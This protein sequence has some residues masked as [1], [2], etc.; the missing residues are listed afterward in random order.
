MDHS[1]TRRD[2]LRLAGATSLGLGLAGCAPAHSGSGAGQGKREFTDAEIPLITWALTSPPRSLDPAH[3][4]DGSSEFTYMEM[5]E[6]LVRFDKNGAPQNLLA[7]SWARPDPLTYVIQLRP[8]VFFWDGKP[9][10]AE[11]AA[12][13]IQRNV[14]PAVASEVAG[15]YAGLESATATGPLELTVK[16]KS[17]DPYFQ[18]TC[19]FAPIIQKAHALAHGADLGTPSGLIMGTGP[20]KIESFSPTQGATLVRND[21]Y[22]GSKSKVAKLELKVIADPDQ[23]RLA[24]QSGEIDGTFQQPLS[25]SQLWD[26][27][28]NVTCQY[29]PSST[30]V[31]LGLDVTKAPFDD[32]HVRR[33]FAYALNRDALVQAVFHGRGRPCISPIDKDLWGSLMSASEADEF[34]ASLPSYKFDMAKSREEL[35]ASKYPNGFDVTIPHDPAR[36]QL[37]TVLQSLAQNLK[38]LGINLTPKATPSAQWLAGLFTKGPK[39][40][41]I[42]A[43][44]AGIPNPA[45]FVNQNLGPTATLNYANYGNTPEI[46]ALIQQTITADAA[47]QKTALMEITKRLAEDVPYAP[48]FFQ[49]Y[50][51]ALNNKYVYN[52]DYGQ[53]VNFGS[54]WASNIRLAK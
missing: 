3:A 19:V 49:D 47:G 27:L 50:T 35:A 12:F 4:A 38:P 48:V 9:L 32:V 26:K 28:P 36:T 42:S 39:G 24:M 5:L 44:S 29:V 16:F 46:A 17:P 25:T 6:P 45:F 18:Y 7:T 33:A 1:L 51:L 15:K 43:E 22:W 30:L 37:G 34:Y 41:Q 23:L 53:W 14:D 2:L 54:E 21:K 20:Y 52:G 40:P 8:N 31:M 11:D 13:S 10:T